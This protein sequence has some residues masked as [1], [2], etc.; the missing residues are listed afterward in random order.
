MVTDDFRLPLFATDGPCQFFDALA[1]SLG[2]GRL[3]VHPYHVGNEAFLIGDR[4]YGYFGL[5]P[6]IPRMLLNALFPA[7][8]GR[9]SR[10]MLLLAAV[11]TV[12][13]THL[14]L[15][16]GGTDRHWR[17]SNTRFLARL[18]F[19]LTVGLGSSALFMSSRPNV[20]HEANALGTALALAGYG[21]LAQYLAW[22]S[23]VRAAVLSLL[24]M[25]AVHARVVSGAGVILAVSGV[26]GLTLLRIASAKAG[27][28][29]LTSL[30][31]RT[32]VTASPVHAAVLCFGM[33]LAI[34]SYAGTNWAKFGT[35][36]S[37][38]IE[39]NLQ[40]TPERLQ[41][42]GGHMLSAKNLR[43]NAYNYLMPWNMRLGEQ[44]ALVRPVPPA[45][46]LITPG[47]DYDWREPVIGLAAASPALVVLCAV[48][49]WLGFA[50]LR[51]DEV[52]PALSTSLLGST[53]SASVPLM[54]FAITQRYAHDMLPFIVVCGSI[55]VGRVAPV[56]TPSLR[57]WFGL[58]LL[59]SV[60]SALCWWQVGAYY[61]RWGKD[62]KIWPFRGDAIIPA[63]ERQLQRNPNDA[64]I[65][66]ELGYIDAKKGRTKQAEV[67]LER[68]L[69]LDP[70]NASSLVLLALQRRVSDPSGATQ[71]LRR[72]V[73]AA[74][75]SVRARTV[76]TEAL[77]ATG[78]RR[79]ALEQLRVALK[80]KQDDEEA[81]RLLVQIL[82]S[83]PAPEQR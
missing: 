32:G 75:L 10:C 47:M 58:L 70:N 49:L 12:L 50:A 41:K 65:H 25:L 68:A 31:K 40:S 20:Y 1:D 56:P 4:A 27:H 63:Y 28:V 44:G 6:A 73:A 45:A 17:A 38:P 19:L 37:I 29:A 9:W 35:A 14:M 23:L 36:L 21:A 77:L 83:G 42:T 2:D 18:A 79:E 57:R 46:M 71:L 43:A 3:D 64:L 54:Y 34:C 80:L 53:A 72:A 66:S 74:P 24:C 69:A 13:G 52:L 5:T 48:G 67:H 76:L 11:I 39:R 78:Q 26:A 81:R 8:W 55:A 60:W 61:R 22:P 51:R 7:L 82:A 59:L 33:L 62:I 16:A 30:L 15:P